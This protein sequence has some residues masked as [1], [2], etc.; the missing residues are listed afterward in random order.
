V[1]PNNPPG[2]STAIPSWWLKVKRAQRHLVD[3]YREVKRYEASHPYEV[4]RLEPSSSEPG[5][6]EYVLRITRQPDPIVAIMV[7]DFLYNLRSALDHVIV[8]SVPAGRRYKASFPIVYRDL[9]E[10]DDEGEYVIEDDEG[11]ARFD[12]AIEGVEPIVDGIIRSCQPFVLDQY[13]DDEGPL[14][15]PRHQLSLISRLENADKHRELVSVATGIRAFMFAR[16]R[17][18]IITDQLPPGKF[19]PDGGRVCR[20]RQEDPTLDESEVYVNVTGPANVK[21][22]MPD[23]TVEGKPMQFDSIRT[24]HGCLR[25]TRILLYWIEPGV[26]EEDRVARLMGS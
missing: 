18:D 21:I 15:G 20:F 9:W 3:I 7:G 6:W 10:K 5:V 23:L 2:E 26:S 1:T 12:A 19:V 22:A 13:S 8:A 14:G 25:L 4:I 24:L 17:Y 11:R 16:I